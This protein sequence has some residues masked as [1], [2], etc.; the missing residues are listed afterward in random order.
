[1]YGGK[2]L[3]QNGVNRG[4]QGGASEGSLLKGFCFFPGTFPSGD[5]SRGLPSPIAQPCKK[6]PNKHCYAAETAFECCC[7]AAGC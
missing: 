3:Q 6:C 5:P 7:S 2:N 1:M 4:L